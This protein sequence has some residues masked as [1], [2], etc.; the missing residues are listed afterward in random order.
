MTL[1]GSVAAA[2]DPQSADAG[3]A[4]ALALVCDELEPGDRISLHAVDQLRR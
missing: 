3:L 4:D 2:L 1:R